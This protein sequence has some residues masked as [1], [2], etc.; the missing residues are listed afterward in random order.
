MIEFWRCSICSDNVDLLDS[1][2]FPS[3]FRVVLDFENNYILFVLDSL[4]YF[5]II[6]YI[7][8][9]YNRYSW[10]GAKHQVTYV[11][12]SFVLRFTFI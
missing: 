10:L 11:L 1:C 2:F 9:W 5:V 7:S 4:I 12:D 3:L 8:P 6:E